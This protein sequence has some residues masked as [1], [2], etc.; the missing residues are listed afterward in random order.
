MFSSRFIDQNE[1]R[2]N[3][4][5]RTVIVVG[6]IGE[7]V[8]ASPKRKCERNSANGVAFNEPKN[9]MKAENDEDDDATASS[10]GSRTSRCC[11][12]SDLII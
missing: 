9:E 2:A 12:V 10:V 11:F 7:S 6:A 3:D 4:A 1:T 8:G 5:E